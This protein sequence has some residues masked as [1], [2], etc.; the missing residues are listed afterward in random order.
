[1]LCYCTYTGTDIVDEANL[2]R[3]FVLDWENLGEH[4]RLK[5]CDLDCSSRDNAHN[6][7]RTKDCCRAVLKRW[8]EVEC[9][10][11]WGKLEDSIN[12]IETHPTTNND[13]TG[14]CLNHKLS[15]EF[16]IVMVDNT[17]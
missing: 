4:L 1:M 13:I 12:A 17:V 2:Y 8:L 10:P 14:K 3:L 5:K 7:N 11:R 6:P 9:T 15:T 16:L